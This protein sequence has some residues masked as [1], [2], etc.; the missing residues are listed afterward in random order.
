MT[1]LDWDRV[2]ALVRD[3]R[4]AQR[5]TQRQAAALCGISRSAWNHV[6]G[7]RGPTGR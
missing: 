1:P 5:L 7:G 4:V 2:A 6:E 3:A